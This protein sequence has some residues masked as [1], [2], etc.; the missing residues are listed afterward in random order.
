M[1]DEGTYNALRAGD[2]GSSRSNL[3]LIERERESSP[4]RQQQPDATGGEHR[5]D[6]DGPA[7][8]PRYRVTGRDVMSTIPASIYHHGNAVHQ[9]VMAGHLVV[10][11]E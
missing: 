8:G 10:V 3:V 6:R 2:G 9:D 5:D 11:D 1:G 4:P 7:D